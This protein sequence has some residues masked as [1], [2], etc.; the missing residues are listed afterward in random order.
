MGFFKIVIFVMLL[1]GMFGCAPYRTV[2]K[3]EQNGEMVEIAEIRQDILGKASYKKGDKEFTVD[4]QKTP[5]MTNV[6]EQ[7][8]KLL[9]LKEIS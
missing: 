8:S 3:E 2:F 1:G 4:T 7:A 5:W 6:A 9:I